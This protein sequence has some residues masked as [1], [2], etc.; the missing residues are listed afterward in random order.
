MKITKSQLREIIREEI[1]RLNEM[2]IRPL[3]NKLYDSEGKEITYKGKSAKIVSTRMKFGK[4][5]ELQLDNP[6]KELAPNKLITITADEYDKA[7]KIV[8]MIK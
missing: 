5:I 6:I 7:V 8:S 1:Q 4:G 2:D 3:M